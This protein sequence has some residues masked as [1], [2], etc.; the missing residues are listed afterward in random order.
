MEQTRQQIGLSKEAELGKLQRELTALRQTGSVQ[1]FALRFR[2]LVQKT[3]TPEG[4]AEATFVS[5]LKPQIQRALITNNDDDTTF[6]ATVDEAI[7][8][9][10]EFY[11]VRQSGYP[12][13]SRGG[14]Q[15]S[16]KRDTKGRFR[17][18][19]RESD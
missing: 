11:N 13:Q 6:Q 19:K 3:G 9:D 7:R 5:K 1:K 12:N 18:I 4:P 2:D 10:S 14:A 16:I 17:N 8:L 15:H